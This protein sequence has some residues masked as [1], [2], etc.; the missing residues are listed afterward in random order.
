MGLPPIISVGNKF[1]FDSSIPVS[2]LLFVSCAFMDDSASAGKSQYLRQKFIDSQN[3]LSS[4][5]MQLNLSKCEVLVP[6]LNIF[7]EKEASE[8]EALGVDLV[9]GKNRHLGGSIGSDKFT[10]DIIKE[11]LLS[12]PETIMLT[13][14]L[15]HPSMH[16]Q[17]ASLIIRTSI[18]NIPMHL[19]RITYPLLIDDMLNKWGSHWLKIYCQCMGLSE[20][21]REFNPDCP[22]PTDFFQNE[23]SF[24][25][26][27]MW[28]VSNPTYGAVR[29]PWCP[30]GL[31]RG[32]FEFYPR[33][34]S[35]LR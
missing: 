15:T 17:F 32:Y 9:D 33:F 27:L 10:H 8:W 4:V 35:R 2:P 7:D 13:K 19:C 12:N 14:C 6:D 31:C 20:F 11:K 29:L 16:P 18:Q 28:Y 30:G 26:N 34:P 21:D 22:A 5:G 24:K 1:Q 23:L 25:F 3:N